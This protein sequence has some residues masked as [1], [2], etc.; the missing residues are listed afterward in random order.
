MTVYMYYKEMNG[1]KLDSAQGDTLRN[2]DDDKQ[3]TEDDNTGDY[4]SLNSWYFKL[5]ACAN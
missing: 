4:K 1:E 5:W 3:H 2:D